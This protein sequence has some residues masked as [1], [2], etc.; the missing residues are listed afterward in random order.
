MTGASLSRRLH[1]VTLALLLSIA[2]LTL[3]ETFVHTDDGC[4]VEVH[5]AACRWLLTASIVFADVPQPLPAH[6]FAIDVPAAPD[7]GPRERVV[8]TPASRGPPAPSI[9]LPL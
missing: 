2:G 9:P 7:D 6:D 8:D 4:A 5:C 3:E 1:W